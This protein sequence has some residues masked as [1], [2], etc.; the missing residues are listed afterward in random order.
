M[1]WSSLSSVEEM[2]F[3]WSHEMNRAF[4]DGICRDA[5]SKWLRSFIDSVSNRVCVSDYFLICVNSYL[6]V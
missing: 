5:D 3:L 2:G 6:C 1:Q 4:V